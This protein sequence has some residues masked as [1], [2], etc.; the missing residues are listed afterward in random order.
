MKWFS[1][2]GDWVDSHGEGAGDRM[3]VGAICGGLLAGALA[4]F[5]GVVMSSPVLA[6]IGVV[7]LCAHFGLAVSA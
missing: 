6:A 2:F 4:M 3:I 1:R 5:I 7:V